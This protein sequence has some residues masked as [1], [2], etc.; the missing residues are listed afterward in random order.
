MNHINILISKLNLM[1]ADNFISSKKLEMLNRPVASDRPRC[2]NYHSLIRSN[3]GAVVVRRSGSKRSL[4][5][6][7][8]AH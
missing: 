2:F 6:F 8:V 5:G 1:S 3:D 4:P 7:N